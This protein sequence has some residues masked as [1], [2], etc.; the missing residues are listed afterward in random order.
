MKIIIKGK[1]IVIARQAKIANF[2]GERLVGLMFK[3]NM[4]SMDALL[5]K[6]CNS[7][8]TCFMRFA[9]DA[10]F[11]DNNFK[12]I[13]VVRNIRPWRMT[14]FYRQAR[15]VLEMHAST[16]TDEIQIGDQLEVADV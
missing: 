9:I 8:H 11:L 12:V 5:I 2:F 10:V 4:G 1:N 7:I 16:L 6:R 13:S 15:Q 14:R 3:K